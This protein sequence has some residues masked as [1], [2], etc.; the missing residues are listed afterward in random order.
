MGTLP[1][2][3]GCY[4]R[5][6]RGS[7]SRGSSFVVGTP[8]NPA[9]LKGHISIQLVKE[10]HTVCL[11]TL[12]SLPM[13]ACPRLIAHALLPRSADGKLAQGQEVLASEL[14]AYP[15]EENKSTIVYVEVVHPETGQKQRVNRSP[16][17][18]PRSEEG[19]VG[20]GG[21]AAARRG[22]P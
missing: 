9:R 2:L 4:P 3:L 20:R 7:S 22:A 16:E 11:A 5:R 18:S 6:G 13:C 14:T 1:F 15:F 12:A 10:S 19:R 17:C 21:G 8:A